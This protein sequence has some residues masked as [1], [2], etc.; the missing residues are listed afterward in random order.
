MLMD[1]QFT[2][3]YSTLHFRMYLVRAAQLG[4]SYYVLLQGV[5]SLD[6][7]FEIDTVRNIMIFQNTGIF[8]LS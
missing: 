3:H 2:K 1:F 8:Y 5:C 4:K 6:V 7:F